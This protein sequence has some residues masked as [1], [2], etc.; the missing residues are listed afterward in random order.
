MTALPRIRVSD[1]QRFLVTESGAPFFWL[2]DTAW[3]L[4]HR[5]TREEAAAYYA[6]R[7]RQR[8]NVVQAVALA[9]FNGL[10]APNAYGELPLIDRDPTRPNDAYFKLVDEYIALAAT[11]GLY[12]ALL[13]TWGDKVAKGLWMSENVIFDEHNAQ[14]YGRWIG[15]RYAAASNVI[16]MLGGDRPAVHGDYDD[17]PLWRAMAAAIRETNPHVLMTYHPS[18]GIGGTSKD[19]HDETW[20]DLNTFQSG[21]GGGRDATT[22]Q[23]IAADYTRTPAKPTLDSEPNY[24]D[25]PV[26]PWPQ[27]KP[28]NGYFRDW[29]VRKQL[30]RSVFAGG[31]G[32]TYGHH[33][34]WQFLSAKFERVNH[35]ECYWTEAITRP[36]AEQARH[37]RELIES[38]PFLTRIPDQSLLI[39]APSTRQ[40]FVCATRDSAGT[41]ALIYI[42]NANQTVRLNLSALTAPIA[43]A[44]W[45]DPRTGDL[46]RIGDID[47]RTPQ[48]FTT[49]GRGPDWVL[50]LGE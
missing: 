16:W 43:R 27:W 34:M 44:S 22:W 25:H 36:G 3:E 42:P 47:T 20:L 33:S 17:R 41:Y 8:F 35:P 45:F 1:N 15:A 5:L 23:M 50:C 48:S 14:V 18:A 39:D 12:V 10:G 32:V 24:E 30:Y 29:D 28:E 21:H 37:L 13:P 9:E 40:D 49:P 26:D 4:F 31:C 6:T 11:H 19:L 38:K 2:G 46:L 7:A